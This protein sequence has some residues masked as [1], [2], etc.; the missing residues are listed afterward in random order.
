MPTNFPDLSQARVIS[1]DLETR[2]DDL[3]SLGPG[4]RRNAYI[5]G[6]SLATE[7]GFKGYYPVAHAQGPNLNKKAVFSWL[8]R[9]WLDLR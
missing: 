9:N 6:I 1:L 8:K 4:V 3:T 7:D 2:D 5:I